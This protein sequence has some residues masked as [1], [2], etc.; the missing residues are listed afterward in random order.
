MPF[1]LLY[2]SCHSYRRRAL[3]RDRRLYPS[4]SKVYF[5]PW[6]SERNLERYWN[7]LRGS[8]REWN[9]DEL[10]KRLIRDEISCHWCPRSEWRFQPPKARQINGVWERFIRN[11]RKSMRAIIKN[12][13]A[14]VDL[15]TLRT[16]FAEVVA[17]LNSRPL[18]PSSDDLSDF[19]PLTPSH[20]LLQ[21]R[22]PA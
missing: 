15:E 11:V 13:N 16:V 19:E 14:L 7:Q 21:R 12:Q 2:L 18:T 5:K 4:S 22:N 6:L 3:A 1:H 20:L 10:N 17:I 9:K 8:I